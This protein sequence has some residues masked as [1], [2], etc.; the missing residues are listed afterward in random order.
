MA[1]QQDKFSLGKFRDIKDK[2]DMAFWGDIFRR[3]EEK[4]VSKTYIRTNVFDESELINF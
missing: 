2:G 3:G 4:D 1:G